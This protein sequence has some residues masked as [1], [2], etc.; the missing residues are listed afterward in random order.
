MVLTGVMNNLYNL[1]DLY[2]VTGNPNKHKEAES[3][4]KCKIQRVD[5]D[6]KEIQDIAVEAVVKEKVLEAYR[7]VKRPVFV[8]DVGFYVEAWNGFPG[9]LVKW[10]VQSCKSKGICK[11]MDSKNRKATL[12]CRIGFYDG[13]KL[14]IFSGDI[15]GRITKYPRGKSDMGLDP[16]FQ[17]EGHTKTFAEMGLLEKNKISHRYLAYMK[18]KKYLKIKS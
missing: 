3:I 8:E 9:A 2:I 10:L 13:K 18:M 12:K 4:L 17:P 14:K 11:M 1:Y 7:Q 15:Q 6:I 16:I 5:I